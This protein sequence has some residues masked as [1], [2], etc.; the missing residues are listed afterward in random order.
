MKKV[1]AVFLLALVA[2]V[3]G[4]QPTAFSTGRQYHYRYKSRALSGVPNLDNQYSGL[5]ILADVTMQSTS[6][7]SGY[8][9]KTVLLTLDNVRVASINQKV[10]DP[11]HSAVYKEHTSSVVYQQELSKPCLV[12]IEDGVVVSI[13][14]EESDPQWSVNYKKGLISTLQLNL[15][16]KNPVVS[17]IE[18]TV[19]RVD[20]NAKI[21]SVYE[22]GIGGNCETWYVIQSIPSPYYPSY[23]HVM[24]ITKTRNYK[25]CIYR[26]VYAH[27]SHDI[28]G[29]P[30]VCSQTSE[31][32][33]ASEY[34][35]HLHHICAGCP[36]GYEPDTVIAKSYSYT[37]YN[38]SRSHDDVVIESLAH[39]GKT[40][41]SAYRDDLVVL[42]YQNLTLISV[43][44]AQSVS[45][46]LSQPVRYSNLSFHLPQS[47]LSHELPYSSP[48][49]P[50]IR[51]ENWFPQHPDY[52]SSG[53]HRLSVNR[54]K[55]NCSLD[56]PFMSIFS[57]INP[58]HLKTTVKETLESIADGI[59]QADLS[60]S[61]TIPYK[62]I[63]LINAISVLPYRHLKHLV[64][65][66]ILSARM[67]EKQQVMRKIL[68]D[69]LSQCGSND[70]ALIVIDLIG[71]EMLTANE[72]REVIEGLPKTLVYPSE[73]TIQAVFE[74]IQNPRVHVNRT[75]FTSASISLGKLIRKACVIPGMQTHRHSHSNFAEQ[76]VPEP[77]SFFSSY[78]RQ[79]QVKSWIPSPV[80]N[81][82]EYIQKIAELL[83]STGE[84]YKKIAYIQTLSHTSHPVALS[85]IKPYVTGL[86]PSCIA[87][88]DDANPAASC[89]FLRQMTIYSLHLFMYRHPLK[90]LSTVVPIY[91]NPREPYE[92]R[93]AAF[94]VLLYNN[95]P[96]YLLERVVTELWS[97]RNKQVANFVYTSLKTLSNSTLPCLQ[98]LA[99]DIRQ[100]IASIRPV[101]LGIQYSHSYVTDFYD[102]PRDYG[103]KL[104][105]EVVQSNVSW[106]PRAGV[107][108]ISHNTGPYI[109]FPI[110]AGF[111]AKGVDQI[112]K[113]ILDK[114][115][116]LSELYSSLWPKY[117][118]KGTIH[119][120][121]GRIREKLNVDIRNPEDPKAV[122]FYTLFGRTTYIPV[123]KEYALEALESVI[124]YHREIQEKIRSGVSGH[125]VKLITPA[126]IFKV[127][128]SEIGLP[129]LISHRRPIIFSLHIKNTRILSTSSSEGHPTTWKI[130]AHIRPSIFYSSHIFGII[131]NPAEQKMYGATIS[132]LN[133]VTLPIDFSLTVKP[134]ST[135]S[136][137]VKPNFSKVFY[138]KSDAGTFIKKSTLDVPVSENFLGNYVPIRTLPIPLKYDRRIGHNALGLGFSVRGLSE[139]IW[140]DT[141]FYLSPTTTQKGYLAGLMEV[142][143]NPGK[144]Y[145]E[146]SV[147][148]DQDHHQPITEY[149][150][151]THYE[152]SESREDKEVNYDSVPTRWLQNLQFRDDYAP[153]FPEVSM[154]RAYQS[155]Y[156]SNYTI[157]SLRKKVH[158]LFSK[159]HPFWKSYKPTMTPIDAVDASVSH[160]VSVVVEGKGSSPV[161][162]LMDLT[163]GYTIDHRISM[164][165][166]HLQKSTS[167]PYDSQP[168]E[169][170]IDG[171]TVYPHVPNEF[172]FDPSSTQEQHT[173]SK[174][175]IRWGPKFSSEGQIHITHI[176][177]KSREQLNS[178]VDSSSIPISVSTVAG[179]AGIGG[180]SEQRPLPWYYK[181]CT[182]D[183][184]DGKSQSYP[185]KLAIEDSSMLNNITTIISYSDVP[186]MWVNLTRK[187]D[188]LMK[189]TYYPYMDN[190]PV[191]AHNPSNRISV[192]LVAIKQIP[193]VPLFN[194]YIQ[195]PKENTYYTKIYLPFVKPQS[196]LVPL[197]ANYMNIFMNHEATTGC[198]LMED[199]VRTFDNVTFLLPD[200]E[201]SYILSKDCSPNQRYAV[202]YNQTDPSTKE[203]ILQVIVREWNI[204]MSPPDSREIIKFTVNGELRQ[205][206]LGLAVKLDSALSPVHLYLHPTA[207]SSELPVVVL[208]AV[209]EGLV[210][211]YD[212]KNVKITVS[213]YYSG[214]HCGLCGDYNGE[215]YEEF[216]GPKMCLY[217]D[218]QDF[219][220]SYAMIDEY[221]V[222][223]P[224][225][226]K[227]VICPSPSPYVSPEVPVV[228][229]TL[230][231]NSCYWNKTVHYKRGYSR[232]FATEPVLV[233]KKNCLTSK[234]ASHEIRG[235]H[236][237]PED[238]DYTY[239]LVRQ[240]DVGVV[241]LL[242]NK[243]VDYIDNVPRPSSCIPMS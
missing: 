189:K 59:C 101:N 50:W 31:S 119:D 201:Y 58:R 90:L 57:N 110:R 9:Q 74:L 118:R 150:I 115:S 220:N 73:N 135:L 203:K 182:I 107:F 198:A 143:N 84:F 15:A 112:I 123:D 155:I 128:P 142:I 180:L 160:S 144:K 158:N 222:P 113:N 94:T 151:T 239:E 30:R 218:S 191:S 236:C 163:F 171:A 157:P 138:H 175:E 139:T 39:H 184:H 129:L 28:R 177:K 153:Y 192:N 24:N 78:T 103:F 196:T 81:P 42:S 197:L 207:S 166:A 102:A 54:Q 33:H 23:G 65:E 194:L 22:D 44:P 114:S 86:S 126:G 241:A 7:Q 16:Q 136:I 32:T 181:Q 130:A 206:V 36:K 76:S 6:S 234:T 63:G 148:I 146:F 75:L 83:E 8:N 125:Y 208:T 56:I 141:P 121:I 14:V 45:Y 173:R 2:A 104:R 62:T 117:Y 131:V 187:L 18:N 212:G 116:I 221:S 227:L 195:T 162:Y 170:S 169:V 242:R 87:L 174:Y 243:K 231:A 168:Y 216:L 95:P 211:K 80:C 134:R 79:S 40:V 172:Y 20:K 186:L 214:S 179:I 205:L 72:G 11:Y 237:L 98:R 108:D 224:P 4:L 48:P 19:P 27:Y 226:R 1:L 167:G 60:N 68:L 161:T 64:E 67:N 38:I 17:P 213:S 127:V 188:L 99:H 12:H 77:S 35:T 89:N 55:R 120:E 106:V 230:T 223:L 200:N 5:E 202:L 225:P 215:S 37:K 41:Y 190:D 140:S 137:S 3:N 29:C 154:K 109:D 124:E 91:F 52:A 49:S 100:V 183:T 209:H 238:D 210:V 149:T 229:P 47:S 240:A 165:R 93:I 92:I 145:R 176:A 53:F 164:T 85:Y 43:V 61:E 71:H 147:W 51:K 13:Q 185:C 10:S 178:P 105:Y 228:W 232:C 25:N 159:T 88:Q 111:S 82:V 233:C 96:T 204:I 21:Y 217:Q 133:H 34:P 66:I 122:L 193:E 156:G 152:W 46:E 132:S 235:F 219:V 97:E 199:Y 69:A 26:P 70:A